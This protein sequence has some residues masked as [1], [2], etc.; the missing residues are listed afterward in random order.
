LH[1]LAFLTEGWL[2]DLDKKS[3]DLLGASI[4]ADEEFIRASMAAVREEVIE[5]CA[6]PDESIIHTIKRNIR[7]SWRCLA[8]QAAPRAEDLPEAMTA[9]AERLE[10]GVSI[11][12]ILAAYRISMGRI[13]RRIFELA[14]VYKIE[15][16]MMLQVST[17][18]WE[19]GDAFSSRAV[20]A[21]R[22][23]DMTRAVMASTRRNQWVGAAV[24][25]GMEEGP[26][27]EGAST[28]HV[29]QDAP[30]AAVTVRC[31][32]SHGEAETARI[33]A[34]GRR[35][36]DVAL[37]SP[38]EDRV[39]GIL[40]GRIPSVKQPSGLVVAVGSWGKLT[41][42]RGSY[43]LADRVLDVAARFSWKGVVDAGSVSWRVALSESPGFVHWS[44]RRF[45]DP[46]DE[47]GDFG[48]ILYE[49]VAAY[50]ASDLNIAVAA[51][52]LT[53]HENT[54]RYRLARFRE[55]TGGDFNK[56]DDLFEVSVALASRGYSLRV[57]DNSRPGES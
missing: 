52:M 34:W 49:S 5:Y 57:H 46:V 14:P 22:E 25:T 48:V 8:E 28:Y 10:Q 4:L 53:V 47:L 55:V 19:L 16:A 3:A 37:L 36:G 20:K 50:L 17:L 35:M 32:E 56:I 18:L 54:L 27:F 40:W 1:F 12:G 43:A 42:L 45:L 26:L 31:N 24:T 11:E 21:Y 23:L 44:S 33:M 2:V 29:P 13:L 39:I 30:V 38:L 41:E 6:V 51:N 9:T 15:P 7:L